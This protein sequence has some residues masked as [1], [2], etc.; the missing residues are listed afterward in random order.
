MFSM[1]FPT[2]TVLLIIQI[3]LVLTEHEAIDFLE[4]L[5]DL[6]GC[7]RHPFYILVEHSWLRCST[8]FAALIHLQ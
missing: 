6:E 8:S 3:Q 2:G 7:V 4:L 1:S 5:L